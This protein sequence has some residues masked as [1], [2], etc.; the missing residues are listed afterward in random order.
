MTKSRSLLVSILR[1]PSNALA[2]ASLVVLAILFITP[3]VG[4]LLSSIKTNRDIA[5]GNF[6][7]IPE[8]LYFGNYAE[9]LANPSMQDYLVNTFIVASAATF[10]SIA[11]SL[12]AAWVFAK[13]QFRGSELIFFIIVS[14]LFFPPQIV[15]IPLF[16]L[17]KALNLI[18]TLWALI[19]AHS[20]HGLPICVLVLRNFFRNV[21][22]ILREAALSDGVS[23][24]QI[25]LRV[26]IPISMPAIAVL[27]TLQFTWIWND[28]L[29]SL[30][31]TNSDRMRTIMVGLVFLNSKY[32]VA[33][34]VQGAMAMMATLPTVVIFLFFQRYFISGLT[35]GAVKG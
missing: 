3:T 23:E 7:T 34:G 5:L 10:F 16:K 32:Q 35:G 27:V 28:F 4:V 11:L 15:L 25:L 30:I 22:T 1:E 19:I 29:W 31:F 2:Q 6:W 12:P 26:A 14:G 9:V 8:T 13:L 17:F 18:D 24:I 21:P 20:A 33:W